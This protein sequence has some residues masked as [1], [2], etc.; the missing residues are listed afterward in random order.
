MGRRKKE[1]T[2]LLRAF[3]YATD[4]RVGHILGGYRYREGPDVGKFTL[5]FQQDVEGRWLI[6][7]DMDNLNRRAH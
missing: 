5:T 1:G 2:L 3:A 4:G 6:L 7:S